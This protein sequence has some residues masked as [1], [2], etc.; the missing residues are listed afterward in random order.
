MGHVR[1]IL[2][3]H[4][5]ERG[6]RTGMPPP[7][8][9][10]NT[11]VAA[12]DFDAALAHHGDAAARFDAG[13]SYAR[14]WSRTFPTLVRQVRG[15]PERMLT[16]VTDEVLPYLTGRRVAGRASRLGRHR[17]RIITDG[18]LDADYTR[19][20]LDGLVGLTGAQA[21]VAYEGDGRFLVATRLH[22]R[23]RI[24]RVTRHISQLRLPLLITSLL[25]A[26]V[27]V[28]L[29]GT[30]HRIDIAAVLLGTV[31]A[32]S[33][34]N[35][36]HDLRHPR[37]LHLRPLN[38][39]RPWL[40]FQA[41]GSYTVA[42]AALLWLALQ[43]PATVG[44]AAAGVAIASQYGRAR[45]AGWGPFVAGLTHGPLI[46]WGAAWAMG[47]D[48]MADPLV[49]LMWALPTGLLAAAILQLDDIADKPLHEASGRR[50]LVVRSTP[51]ANVRWFAFMTVAAT[52]AAVAIAWPERLMTVAGLLLILF[53]GAIVA[54]V[55]QHLDD[56]THL[57]T[58]RLLLAGLYATTAFYLT[59]L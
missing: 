53:A 33:G 41:L 25:A 37:H 5:W 9:D 22:P 10:P 36:M 55:R 47:A 18:D 57:A 23:D 38:L 42:L 45:D 27:G 26:A 12:T 44:F 16:I 13:R 6:R 34:A 20:L 1:G 43:Q 59:I 4:L 21:N 46:V 32:Q 48:L 24:V 54:D 14:L 29:A 2:W 39:S 8:E 3:Q 19:G 40:W 7:I 52:A 50:T 17:F 51:A 30:T 11:L 49:S 58:A 28:A 56:P 15:E 35:A 31:A